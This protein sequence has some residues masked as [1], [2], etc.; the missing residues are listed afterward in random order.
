MTNMETLEQKAIGLWTRMV[1]AMRA[2]GLI[3]HVVTQSGPATTAVIVEMAQ[4]QPTTPD[5][6]WLG[7]TDVLPGHGRE[8][9]A[10]DLKGALHILWYDANARSWMKGKARARADKYVQWRFVDTAGVLG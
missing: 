7:M 9:V 10:R 2:D 5:A 8:V 6:P 3:A 1:E 4:G